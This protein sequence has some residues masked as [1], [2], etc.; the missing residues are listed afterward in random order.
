M[1]NCM[2]EKQTTPEYIDQAIRQGMGGFFA[3]V[4]FVICAVW[5][6][7]LG[8]AI[9]IASMAAIIYIIKKTPDNWAEMNEKTKI[10]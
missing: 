2:K 1:F 7:W 9:F 4:W 3:L 10:W 5:W 6:G 8:V